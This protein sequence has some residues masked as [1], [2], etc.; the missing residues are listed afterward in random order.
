MTQKSSTCHLFG[1]LQ[2]QHKTRETDAGCTDQRQLHR[3]KRIR[4]SEKNKNDTQQDGIQ[5]LGQIQC[6]DPLDVGNDRPSFA[7]NIPKA[8][9][10]RIQQDNMCR[11]FCRITSGCHRNTA[12]CILQCKHVVDTVTNHTDHF[13]FRLISMDKLLLL[14]RL[15]ASKDI[16]FLH[17][18]PVTLR[19]ISECGGIHVFFCP[20]K[21][22]FSGNLR[23][24]HRIVTGD[25]LDLYHLPTEVLKDVRCFFPDAVQDHDQSHR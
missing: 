8:G 18:F 14:F 5:C 24:R 2:C 12:V 10:I 19:I 15:H 7:Y 4:P 21:S 17:G 25:H 3:D 6:T 23:Y 13:L 1:M 16:I 9:K 20:Q 22:C 11:L